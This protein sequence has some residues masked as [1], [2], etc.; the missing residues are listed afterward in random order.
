MAWYSY[1][2]GQFLSED[3]MD[4]ITE[5]LV[6]ILYDS[7]PEGTRSVEVMESV[8]EHTKEKIQTCEIMDP[9]HI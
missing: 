8:L 6:I 9:S 2:G 3:D 5:N 1:G 7:L 4:A